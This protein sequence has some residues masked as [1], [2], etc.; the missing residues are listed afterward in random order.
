VEET[1]Q[2]PSID[3]MAV[4]YMACMPC[5]AYR[6]AASYAVA[7]GMLGFSRIAHYPKINPHFKND[8]YS[9]NKPSI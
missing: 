9:P 2:L 3:R 5:M 6:D 1:Y 8:T 7:F 4:P